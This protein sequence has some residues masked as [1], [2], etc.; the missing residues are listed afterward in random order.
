MH[1]RTTLTPGPSPK[2]EG[3][4]R[5]VLNSSPILGAFW[6]EGGQGPGEGTGAEKP[7]VTLL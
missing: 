1:E 4:H 6:G 7:C 2:G 3:D 5:G